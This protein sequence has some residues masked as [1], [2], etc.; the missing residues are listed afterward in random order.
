MGACAGGVPRVSTG[1]TAD[2][3]T[4]RTAHARAALP[5]AVD[6]LS[7]LRSPI[8]GEV[9]TLFRARVTAV[10][11]ELGTRAASER[12][13]ER[14]ACYARDASVLDAI[15][16]RALTAR[17][18][19]LPDLLHRFDQWSTVI[20]SCV[21][22]RPYTVLS[23]ALA[24]RVEA[25]E[26]EGIADQVT[27]DDEA[28]RAV[29]HR[30]IEA[31]ER[32]GRLEVASRFHLHV[33]NTRP[34]TPAGEREADADCERAASTARQAASETAQV[35]SM[36]C[37][38]AT[39]RGHSAEELRAHLARTEALF[40]RD[41]E[42]VLHATRLLANARDLD[43]DARRDA[44]D[45]LEASL[46]RAGPRFTHWLNAIRVEQ[47]FTRASR[48]ETLAGLDAAR[49]AMR[50]RE[51]D[52]SLALVDI[53]GLRAEA[54]FALG[55]HE[56]ARTLG[57]DVCTR[58]DAI[59]RP[60]ANGCT[61]GLIVQSEANVALR[62]PFACTPLTR[63]ISRVTDH[64]GPEAAWLV[65]LYSRLG[66]CRWELGQHAEALEA[67]REA[68]QRA[69][70]E[71]SA[72]SI[73]TRTLSLRVAILSVYVRDWAGAEQA[74][75]RGRPIL[76]DPSLPSAAAISSRRM[77]SQVLLSFGEY[78]SSADT[79]APAEAIAEAAHLDGVPLTSLR[80]DLAWAF[81]AAGRYTEAVRV[82]RALLGTAAP[83]LDGTLGD[84]LGLVEAL[85]RSG[86]IDGAAREC[87][88]L[89]ALAGDALSSQ[90]LL[91]LT[92]VETLLDRRRTVEA[93]RALTRVGEPTP[94]ALRAMRLLS[95]AAIAKAR[96]HTRDVTESLTAAE[97]AVRAAPAMV[98]P[99]LRSDLTRLR[100]P[101]AGGAAR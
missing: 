35:L 61:H 101:R 57:V 85:R 48:A 47:A 64:Q 37:A 90:P 98:A 42:I 29:Y 28:A 94:P 91:A 32:E 18:G 76:D 39:P 92:Q 67:M 54:M 65:S 19:S 20:G 36:A 83:A 46:L 87:D 30:A 70:R 97:E 34:H 24:E 23:P 31:S 73:A 21:G 4:A 26:A 71:E 45:R 60:Y 43:H 53:D 38:F 95:R 96:R 77:I 50:S 10:L 2:L 66:A 63:A 59:D 88:A 15:V 12:A 69:T 6:A 81:I 68:E 44:L 93:E 82:F 8:A 33:A 11:E 22:T 100:E 7:R 51:G 52:G 14:I 13:P 41:A 99:M 5:A 9:S 3:I 86:D 62:R 79:L 80:S 16:S 78:A 40:E 75:A 55:R 17:A 72:E 84:R 49:D 58:A 89:V 27:G 56:E 25:L 74:L 1:P